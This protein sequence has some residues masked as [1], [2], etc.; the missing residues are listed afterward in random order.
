M[1]IKFNVEPYYDDFETATAVDGLTPKEKY[2][3]ILFRPGHAVQARE[4]TQLQSILQNQVT[5]VSNNLFKEGSLV[6]PG[7]ST[8]E[9]SLDYVK[10]DSINA[11]DMTQLKSLIFTDGHVS[12][13]LTARVVH[14]EA[15][16][17]LDPVTL[18]VKYTS[19][20]NAGKSKFVSSDSIT[21]STFTGVVAATA[22]TGF[23]SIASIEDGIYFIKGHMVVVKSDT[24]I[25]DKYTSNPSYDVG[26]EISE[27]VQTSA[28]D[29]SL[30][31]NA[32]GTPNYAAPGAHRYQISTKLIKETIGAVSSSN[33]LLLIRI[34]A[35]AISHHVR[36]TEYAVIEETLARRTFDESG[37]YT[38]RPFLMDI[39]EH[40]TVNTPGDTTKL[41][42]GMEPSKAYVRGYEI[43]TLATTQVA[44]NKARESTLF[45]AASVPAQVGNYVVINAMTGLPYINDFA[46]ISLKNA[47]AGIIG[48]ARARSIVYNGSG[49]YNLYLFDIEMNASEVFDSVRT[50]YTA[51]SPPF[52]ATVV[53]DSGKAIIK[54]P[55]RNT[56]VFPTPFDRVKT[57][58]SSADNVADDFNYVY[59][60][61]RLIGTD[62]V[63][64]GSV[65]FS[66]VG[67]AEQFEPHDTE[68]WILSAADGT[69]ITIT[70]VSIA[71]G[72][73]SVTI[74]G[75]GAYDATNVTLIAG[76][77]RSLEHKAKSLTTAGSP[78]VNQ[79][80]ISSPTTDM[81]L[82]R[83]DGY[84][85]LNVYMS[86]SMGVGAT[87]SDTD[88]AEYYDFDDGQRDNFYALSRIKLK[89]TTAFVP[90][91]QLMVKYE[92]FTHTGSGD[93]FSVD[94]YDN[95]VDSTGNA[96][97]YEDIPKFTSSSIGKTVELRSSIDFR[98]R[99]SNAGE[100]FSGTGAHLTVCPEPQTTFTTDI[101]YY[102]N[103]IDKVYIDKGGNFG[104]VE[105][106][107]SLNPELPEDP[108]DAMVLYNL[109]M[110]AYTEGPSEVVPTMIDNKRYT[111]R[112]IG[113]IEKRV[114]N[115][116]YY[117]S[118]SLLEQDASSR[119]IIDSS[120]GVQRVKSGFIV[121]SFTTHNIG[122]VSNPEYRSAIDRDDHVLR[123]QFAADNVTLK[124]SSSLSTGVQKTGDLVTLPYTE[125]SLANQN[126]ASGWMNVNPFDVF[127]WVGNIELSPATDE[128]RDTTQRPALVIDQ[129]GVYD[130]MMG[131]LDETNAL[132]TV[133]NDWQTNW[134]GRSPT[135]S[136]SREGR[137]I[138]T[139][140]TTSSGQSR[141]GIN[142][143]V[144]PDTISTNI[145]DR[146]VDVNF[147]PFIRSR[148]VAFKATRLKPNTQ[149]YA[150]FDGVSVADYVREESTFLKHTD[151]DNPVLTG[152][153]GY[154]SH[155]VGSSILT[156]DA[157]GEVIGSFFIPNNAVRSFKTGSR[158]FKLTDSVTNGQSET[159]SEE[160]YN[161][162]GLIE[163][164]ENVTIST[165]VPTIERR[166]VPDNRIVPVSRVTDVRWVDP[167]AQS[168]VIDETGGAFI[169]SIDL[170]FHTKD[171]GESVT[172]QVREMSQGIPTQVIVPFSE[173]TLYPADVNVVDLNTDTPSPALSTN[174]LFNSPVYLQDNQ[175]YCFVILANSNQYNVWYAGIGEDDYVSGKRISKQP[176]AGV[177]FKSQNASTW[178][179]DQNK[180]I[181]FKINRAEFDTSAAGEL[182]IVNG[183]TADRA[184]IKHAIMSTSGSTIVTVS[185]PNHQFF[186][187]TGSIASKVTISGAVNFNGLTTINGTHTVYDVEMD[188]YK[189][190]L[191]GSSNA[192]GT[193]IGGGANIV[194]SQNQL[195]NTFMP[196]IQSI[197]LPGT[198]STW[199]VKLSTATNLGASTPTPYVL[200]SSYSPVIINQNHYVS[201]P[202][203]I[204]SSDNKATSTMVVRGVL[205]STVSNISPVIDLERCSIITV[206]NRIDNPE[207]ISGTDSTK[208]NIEGFIAETASTGGSS[209]AK[210]VSKTITLQKASDGLH[211]FLD[212]NR[213][214]QTHIDVYYKADDS[215]D[216][217]GNSDWV[218]ASPVEQIPYTDSAL[219]T[220][221]EYVI[222]PTGTFTS[223]KMKIVLRSSSSSR[224]PRC[225]D[226]R[227]VAILP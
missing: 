142:T 149:V 160:N 226:M 36:A 218:L 54:D 105:G 5:Q 128:W 59:Y 144:V 12:S 196:H 117:T 206:A 29:E 186:N 99:E 124:Y 146:V 53:L 83:A 109:F 204:A 155:P 95:L 118:L 47:S 45:E 24:I 18:Y 165:R 145:G 150:F 72:S 96:V 19:T 214:S 122:D 73:Q 44:T 25:L 9:G 221:S 14:A 65:I 175:E 104:I 137:K 86:A 123:P 35:G 2:N 151:L 81:Q 167:L 37:N 68:N 77:K 220:E 141:T 188:S 40:T 168:F 112:D 11:T 177:L 130:A 94:S 202:K 173:V 192:T 158:L 101:Q 51:G 223:F 116:E 191:T 22:P 85:L 164:K 64:S 39:N 97:R 140:T 71:S 201:N 169:T 159:S 207:I 6:I 7:H 16:S 17:G 46:R 70:S 42:L 138:T 26:L 176:Y 224:I 127:S 76:V 193:G 48:F 10:L 180:D 108:K 156:A 27:A 4:L 67:T 198:N 179:P 58:D 133:W 121:D 210:Y 115:L 30:N 55:S 154:T 181:K 147:A 56:M 187:T 152:V 213:P 114:N 31:D 87:S 69:I 60:C 157:N 172:L 209:K 91:G 103:R 178:S 62:T 74:S 143:F 195:I 170:F 208:N 227:I 80:T 28:G 182:V 135:S 200:D 194:A 166:E 120:T 134:S 212:T 79:F 75:L 57:C 8:I 203:V 174:F 13:P 183:S 107:S 52:D 113:R 139:T 222:D 32:N 21:A 171:V 66:T 50:L 38:V 89:P 63:A 78:N 125:V 34:T 197:T 132:G 131:I 184:L 106:V 90:T 215:E 211:M 110:K 136:T 41:S 119:Q 225:R 216:T 61:N 33:F 15:A 20:G 102:L 93:F 148:I 1:T 185:H 126:Q 3:K 153:N 190:N 92:F 205:S 163:T 162:K 49:A 43:E 189:I 161:A 82:D 98:P 219:F 129:E 217:L 23:G 111:M 84:K 88:V 100:N 199:G